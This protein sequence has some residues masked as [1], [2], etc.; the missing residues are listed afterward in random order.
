[1][2]TPD[3]GKTK[4]NEYNLLFEST[5]CFLPGLYVCNFN[6]RQ[7]ATHVNY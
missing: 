5:R 1:M 6:T 3:T 2:K 7:T 4:E